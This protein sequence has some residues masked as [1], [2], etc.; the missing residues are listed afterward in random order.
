MELHITVQ[1]VLPIWEYNAITLDYIVGMKPIGF[2]MNTIML[3]MGYIV[4]IGRPRASS[5]KPFDIMWKSGH[6]LVITDIEYNEDGTPAVI[7]VADSISP[8]PQIR[9]LSPSTFDNAFNN[10]EH[11]HY[12]IAESYNPSREFEDLSDLNTMG[13]YLHI[14][15]RLCL[16]PG[17]GPNGN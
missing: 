11:I 10:A 15:G 2:L 5:M 6:D 9:R 7:E 12:R 17:K 16:F 1:N 14:L 3:K 4:R 13:W 8:L